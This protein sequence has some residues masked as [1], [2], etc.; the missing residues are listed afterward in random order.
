MR[1]DADLAGLLGIAGA[2]GPSPTATSRWTGQAARRRHRGGHDAVPRDGRPLGAGGASSVATLY[3]D[4]ST[5]DA[6]ARRDLAQRRRSRR[7]GRGVHVRPRSIRRLHAA[8]KS[9]W[10]GQERDGISPVRSDD[11]FFGAGPDDWLD[12]SKVHIPQADEQQRLLANLITG[13]NLDRAPLPRFWYLPRGLPAAVV[14]TGD[15]H[16]TGGTSGQFDVFEAQSPAGCSVRRLGVRARDVLRVPEHAGAGRR[17]LPGEGFELALHLD[18]GC[19]N[20]SDDSL[21][22]MW[23]TQAAAFASAVRQPADRTSSTHCSRGAAG[24]T[25]RSSSARTGCG[26][27]RTTTTGRGR[28][29][30][31]RP[32]MFTGSGFPMRFADT[33]GTL[34][35]VYQ[36]ATQ[37][38]DEWGGTQTEATGVAQHIQ[39]LLARASGPEGFYGVFTA[40]MHTD[41]PDHPGAQAIVAAAKSR[42]VPVVSAAQMLDWLDAPERVV[43]PGPRLRRG[44]TALPRRAR[45][46]CARARGHG[47]GGRRD[48]RAHV[49]DARRRR[50]EPGAPRGQGDRVRRLPGRR[51]HVR[52]H[53]RRRRSRVGAARP[54][55]PQGARPRQGPGAGSGACGSCG[56]A[57]ASRPRG[58]CGC[59]CAAPGARGAAGS[60]CG[61]GTPDGRSRSGRSRWSAGGPPRS[62]CA[63]RRAPGGGRARR[64]DA[65]QGRRPP[66][67]RRG[68]SHRHEDAAPAARAL[69]ARPVFRPRAGAGRRS[70][71]AGGPTRRR[72]PR[73]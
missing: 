30:M 7:T 23:S 47:A 66:D 28:W 48:R 61:S 24:R 65:G 31:Y 27:T 4:A 29:A 14:M 73:R 35:D 39:A 26:S 53:V 49:A 67:E 34:I 25:T 43:L 6:G 60:T 42:G 71:R 38:T 36:A 55:V 33:D 46:R 8:G 32:G 40:N 3:A 2:G 37:L 51:G 13:M 70:R 17:G 54:V 15:D 72:R 18:T 20:Q 11:L 59:G 62:G 1:P 16:G 56:T 63:S 12:R 41:H 64:L 58:S 19:A 5:A 68:G 10:A 22:S 50:G 57:P 52:G 9:G 21:R 45:R 44:A 69:T